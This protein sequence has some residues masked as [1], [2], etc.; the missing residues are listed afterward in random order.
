MERPR[1]AA[2]NVTYWKIP[3]LY[4]DETVSSKILPLGL[5]FCGMEPNPMRFY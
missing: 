1:G 3:Q 4:G 5:Q 2:K